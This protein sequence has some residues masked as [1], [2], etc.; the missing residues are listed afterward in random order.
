[1]KSIA[2][3]FAIVA[4]L[5]FTG[6][7]LATQPD[8][9]HKVG[10]CHRTASDTNP[11]VYIE[12][13]EAAL[14]PGHLDNDDPGHKPTYWKSDG[15]FRGVAHKDGDPKDDYLAK[16]EADCNDFVPTPSPTATPV[17]PTATP[18]VPTATP[19]VPTP[20]PVVP[21]VPPTTPPVTPSPTEVPSVVPS[22][23]PSVVP[24]E[25]PTEEPITASPEV[26]LPETDTVGGTGGGGFGLVLLMLAA[27]AG[28]AMLVRAPKR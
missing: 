2:S 7:A 14:S 17:V 5:V 1:M 3:L 10:I 4:L 28:T 23:E 27:V 19:V 9:D 20:T 24:S 12:V 11:Y 6:T 21:T 26:I 15:T 8:P 16:S 18:V 25:V 22:I 13:D